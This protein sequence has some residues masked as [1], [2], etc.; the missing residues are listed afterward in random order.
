MS[1][2]V[3]KGKII[4]ILDNKRVIV[5]LGYN[6]SVK[7]DMRFIIYAEGED[8]KDPETN[9]FLGKREIVKHKI[10]ATHIQENFSIMESDVWVK[11]LSDFLFDSSHNS[12]ADLLLKEDVKKVEDIDLAVKV[13]DLVRQDIS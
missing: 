10:K 13:G 9:K 5:N 1:Q 6:D 7:K 3:L 8:I 2:E 4:K 11:K 12:Q